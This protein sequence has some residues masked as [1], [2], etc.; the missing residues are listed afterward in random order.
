MITIRALRSTYEH[1]AKVALLENGTIGVYSLLKNLS[2][3]RHEE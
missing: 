3:M 2:P 1:R